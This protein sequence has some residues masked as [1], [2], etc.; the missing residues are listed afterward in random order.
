MDINTRNRTEL[1]SYFTKN[2]IPTESNFAEL[3]EGTLNQKED[4]LVKSPGTPLS[5]EA[6]GDDSSPQK[7]LNL[8][9]DFSD[10]QPEWTLGLN[11]RVDPDEPMVPGLSVTDGEGNSRLFIDRNTGNVGIGA[12]QPKA[13]L[14]INGLKVGETGLEVKGDVGYSHIPHKD[15]SIYLTAYVGEGKNGKF[16]FRTYDG[17]QYT[18]QFVID[19]ATGTIVQEV[20]EEVADNPFESRRF[21]N[22][23][24]NYNDEYNTAAYFK[25]SMGIVH[26]KG[27]VKGGSGGINATIFVLPEGYRPAARELRVAIMHDENTARVDIMPNGRVVPYKAHST[28]TSLDGITFRAAN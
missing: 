10:P 11:L 14:A 20:W 13:K 4:G 27:L 19:G 12:V 23:W 5:V 26:L 3:I 22:G 8:Y 16:I 15:G 9:R 1:K 18:N 25:D 7:A 28:W 17:T 24:K 6:A 2:S 21:Q